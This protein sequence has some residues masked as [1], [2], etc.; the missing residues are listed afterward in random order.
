VVC[1]SNS[2]LIYLGSK[3]GFDL[4]EHLINNQQVLDQTIDLRNDL[5]KIAYGP[6]GADFTP[7]LE[8]HVKGALT[9]LAKLEGFCVGPYMC[10]NVM[11]SGDFHVFEMIDQHML[12]CADTGVALDMSAYP[13]LSVLHAKVR[14][15]PALRGYFA[16]D[17]YNK[18][19]VNNPAYTNYKGK[20]YVEPFGPTLR[21]DVTFDAGAASTGGPTP[22]VV[23]PVLKVALPCVIIQL[24]G[25]AMAFGAIKLG[26]ACTTKVPAAVEAGQHY[27]CAGL[28]V[29]AFVMRFVNM[30][31]AVAFKGAVMK[32]PLRDTIGLNMRSNPFIYTAVASK[33]TVVFENDGVVGMYNRANRSLTHMT[34]NFG[35][36]LAGLAFLSSIF[37][38]PTLVCACAFGL[39]R[40]VHQVGYAVAYGKHGIG[41]M[42]STLAT[43]AMEGFI[44]L[45]ALHGFGLLPLDAVAAASPVEAR[46]SA[47]EA[48]VKASGKE[49]L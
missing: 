15:D 26:G 31:P 5:M 9:H 46:L 47:L 17:A 28:A 1:Q 30:Y 2:C 24:V 40:V 36:V 10:G 35:S 14:G 11:Q 25:L 27:A 45:V 37:P 12:M 13:K 23:G 4:P 7:A 34:E 48:L 39:G 19:A 22:G 42:L 3:L 20:Y 41:F 16:S 29:I 8:K 33:E 21:F 18:Y 32:G 49:E 44:I 6:D 43:A 38:L